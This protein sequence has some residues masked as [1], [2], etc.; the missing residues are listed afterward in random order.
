MRVRHVAAVLFAI[1]LLPRVV[2]ALWLD[3]EPAW[4]GAYYHIGARSIANGLGYAGETGAPWSHYPVGYSALIGGAYALFGAKPIVATMVNAVVGAMLST[5]IYLL[6]RHAT[7]ERRARVAGALTALYPGLVIYT[8]LLMT[9]PVAALCIVAAALTA[10]H[11]RASPRGAIVAGLLLGLGTLVRPQSLLVAPFVGLFRR[12]RL[13][14]PLKPY[15]VAGALCTATT[16]LVVS[17]WTIRNCR[18]M[19]GC[20]FVST[21]TGWNLAIGSF[22][23]ATGRFETLRAGD[24]CHIVTGQAQQDRCWVDLALDWI[25]ADPSRW[26]RMM[27]D[28]LGFTFDHESFPVGYLSQ[29]HASSWTEPRKRI[30]R[31]VLSWAHRALLCLAAFGLLSR[32]SRSRSA[33][34]LAPLSLALLAWYAA[35]SLDHPFW[36]IAVAMVVIAAVRW[37]RLSTTALFAAVTVASV[38]VTH[39]VF[40]GEDR[41]HVVLTPLFCLLAACVGQRDGETSAVAVDQSA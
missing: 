27:P 1:A 19:D 22:P 3:G 21:N 13:S 28:K 30:G 9:E 25:A 14:G 40:F 29:M 7:N 17:P 33:S 6:A 2:V 38:V 8:A 16:L 18:T 41:Y 37:R 34:L 35:A 24:G 32:A 20:A 5:G 39:A 26:I 11:T 36:L 31:G 12:P 23:R 10:A 15:L 4:D